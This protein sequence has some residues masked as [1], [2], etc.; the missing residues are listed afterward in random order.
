MHIVKACIELTLILMV[1]YSSVKPDL[2]LFPYK[3]KTSVY[4]RKSVCL[5]QTERVNGLHIYTSPLFFVFLHLF[6]K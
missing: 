6:Y 2:Y 5:E 3:L 1:V 4:L